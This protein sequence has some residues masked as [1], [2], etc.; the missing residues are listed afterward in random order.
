[1][2]SI[3]QIHLWILCCT[4]I[5][6]ETVLAPL[7]VCVC[8]CAVTRSLSFFTSLGVRQSA[9]AMRGTTFTLSCRA[10]MNSISTGRSLQ[11]D[12]NFTEHLYLCMDMNSQWWV[13]V[14]VC[15][16]PMSKRRYEVEAAVNSVVLDVLPVE[17]ALVSEVLFKLLINVICDGPPATKHKHVCLCLPDKLLKG[18][19]NTH[20]GKYASLLFW[21]EWNEKIGGKYLV[22]FC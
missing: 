2:Y 3:S 22:K 4:F 7:G 17:S 16:L 5:H 15:V 12:E 11:T 10:F 20:F 9:F 14:C 6:F 1:M 18:Q 13:C 19:F 8:V 21:Q